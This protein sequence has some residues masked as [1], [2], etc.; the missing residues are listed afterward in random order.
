MWFSLRKIRKDKNNVNLT[1]FVLHH[2]KF[3][4][5][6]LNDIDFSPPSTL[7][8]GQTRD[9]YI[10]LSVHRKNPGGLHAAQNGENPDFSVAVDVNRQP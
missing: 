6:D 4:N 8:R 10:A 7:F 5:V 9:A 1:D 2:N 3:D